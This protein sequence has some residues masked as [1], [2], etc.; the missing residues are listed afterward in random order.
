MKRIFIAGLVLVAAAAIFLV[1]RDTKAPTTTKVPYTQVVNAVTKQSASVKQLKVTLEQD[2]AVQFKDKKRKQLVS[3]YPGDASLAKL[4]DQAIADGVAVKV[5]LKPS[6]PFWQGL[7]GTLLPLALI[8]GVIFWSVKSTTSIGGKFKSAVNEVSGTNP[9]LFKDV[10]GAG[11]ALEEVRELVSFL[12][13]PARY[14]RLG[15]KVPRGYM[16]V[17]PPG[18]GK[19]LMAKALAG[20]SGAS[21]YSVSGSDFVEIFAGMGAK[22][23]RELF[24]KARENA[25]S[26]IFIDEIDAI[27]RSRSSNS[28]G[29]SEEREQTL[30]QLLVEMDGFSDREAVIV[31]AATNRADVL[32]AALLRPGRFDRQ[33]SVEVPDMSGRLEILRVHAA[34]KPVSSDTLERIASQTP[35]FSGADLEHLLNEAAIIATRRGGDDIS[36]ADLAQAVDRVVAGLERRS[37]SITEHER[38]LIAFH[39]VGHAMCAHLSEHPMP[40]QRISAVSRGRALGYTMSVHEGDRVLENAASLMSH[41]V[42]LMGGRAAELEMFG[43]AST[44]CESDLQRASAIARSMV[45]RFGMSE[46]IGLQYVGDEMV[47][48]SSATL[49]LIDQEVAEIVE[50]A[51]AM[52]LELLNKNRGALEV[53]AARLREVE[54]MHQD[55]FLALLEGV[56]Q[57][58][59]A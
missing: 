9:V 16:F 8:G 35:G 31:I 29:G 46:K 48:A 5:E 1:T 3:A 27:G 28:V 53:I 45:T 4:T 39:E 56:K 44:G 59:G 32:D 25:P 30:N 14:A 49:A 18:T 43:V 38:Q 50:R 12:N 24:T 6:A 34:G 13:D 11:P 40:V 51:Q 42:M 7:L 52:A 37:L 41:L 47:P 36:N 54:T 21:F 22:R 57:P 17:G 10:A 33:I 19:T 55:E 58:E 23:I 26:I 20:E 2:V 15:A